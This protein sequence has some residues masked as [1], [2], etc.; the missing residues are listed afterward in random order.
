M[1]HQASHVRYVYGSLRVVYYL[2]LSLRETDCLS[3]D[4]AAPES[5]YS[6]TK[7]TLSLTTRQFS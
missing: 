4:Y 1:D 6:H 5:L 2:M 3:S 7:I